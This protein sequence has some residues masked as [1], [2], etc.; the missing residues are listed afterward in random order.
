[1]DS[2]DFLFDDFLFFQDFSDKPQFKDW[3]GKFGL[4]PPKFKLFSFNQRFP[5]IADIAKTV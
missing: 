1:M 3:I 2:P 5:E 4:L